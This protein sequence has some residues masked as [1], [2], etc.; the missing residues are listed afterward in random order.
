MMI[1]DLIDEVDFK[2]RLIALGAPVTQDQSLVE[3]QAT[4]L[5]WLRAYPEQTPF[6]KDLCTEMQKDNTTVLPE[7]SSVMAVFS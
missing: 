4:V 3:V 1:V 2:E 6:V 7:V 5:S